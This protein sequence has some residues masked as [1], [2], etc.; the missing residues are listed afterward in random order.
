MK[1]LIL[2][3]LLAVLMMNLTG[4]VVVDRHHKTARKVVVVDPGPRPGRPNRPHG[5]QNPHRRQRHDRRE[6][7]RGR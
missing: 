4:C 6:N 1:R 3:I 5:P 2:T 7:R